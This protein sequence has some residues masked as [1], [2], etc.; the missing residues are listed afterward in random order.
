MPYSK[1]LYQKGLRIL[2]NRR[3]KSFHDLKKKQDFLYKKN[4]RAQEIESELTSTAVK[5]AKAVINGKKVNKQLILLKEKNLAL[6]AELK[7][8]LKQNGLPKDYLKIKHRCKL[9]KDTGFVDGKMCKCFKE[10][11]KK[12]SYGELNKISPLSL[13]SFKDFSLDF[14]PNEATQPDNIV[15]KKRMANILTY[16]KNYAEN[17][18][19]NS[20][21]VLMRGGTGLGKT[22]LSLA[23][24]NEVI[25]KGYSV[26]YVSA[27]DILKKIENEKFF[28]EKNK[29]TDT[30]SY[31]IECDLLIL[32]DLGTEF[33]TKFTSAT[34]YNILNSRLLMQK[35]TIISTN[36]SIDE[37]EKSYSPRF[38]SRIIGNTE[39]LDFL[40]RDIRQK[41]KNKK[42]NKE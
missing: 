2:E 25:D 29:D 27:P 26:I 5:I 6:Q 35:P 14:Y 20:A 24:A 37:L 36:L 38:V 21:S 1:G 17:F 39:R 19:T 40:G 28:A 41:L 7:E 34:I 8:I 13:C 32:D 18:K 4:K 9:C 33:E 12:I 3:A 42:Q 23:I 10:I 30:M 11:L 31:L 16:C 15:P 22:H